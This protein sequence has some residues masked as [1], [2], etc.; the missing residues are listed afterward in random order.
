MNATVTTSATA[1]ATAVLLLD[2]VGPAW[3]A[4]VLCAEL[5][6]DEAFYVLSRL[7]HPQA[8]AALWS[9]TEWLFVEHEKDLAV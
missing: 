7:D 8:H 3:A 9:A 5:G 4:S 1:N 2:V 6:W